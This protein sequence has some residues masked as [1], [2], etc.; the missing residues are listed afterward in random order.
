MSLSKLKGQKA[1][2]RVRGGHYRQMP[3]GK[4]EAETL[5]ETEASMAG[6]RGVRRKRLKFREELGLCGLENRP[7]KQECQGHSLGHSSD[8]K[9]TSI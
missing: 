5:E 8:R 2:V 6:E 4:K 3:W 7:Q 1:S 9:S